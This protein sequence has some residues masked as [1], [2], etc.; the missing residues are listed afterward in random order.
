[1]HR[2]CNQNQRHAFEPGESVIA[3]KPPSRFCA[4]AS[5]IKFVGEPRCIVYILNCSRRPRSWDQRGF[6]NGGGRANRRRCAR[7][8]CFPS[9]CRTV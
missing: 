9:D 1:M 4:H 2:I 5:R 3:A 8:R 6:R 7:W